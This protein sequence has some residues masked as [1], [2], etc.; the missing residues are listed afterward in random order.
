MS[1]DHPSK[2]HRVTEVPRPCPRCV[3]H[4]WIPRNESPGLYPGALSRTDNATEICSECGE[5][6]ALLDH[7]DG[8]CQPQ[9][10]WPVERK[11][12]QWPQS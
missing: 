10:E 9:S 4:S 11:I 12:R 3:Q 6:E 7:F 1:K 2:R 8:G 5:D